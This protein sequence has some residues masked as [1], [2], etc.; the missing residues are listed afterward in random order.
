VT[1][2]DLDRGWTPD[3]LAT[4][5]GHRT[6]ESQALVLRAVAARLRDSAACP[7]DPASVL[8]DLGAAVRSIA[9]AARTA[10]AQLAPERLADPDT[11]DEVQ[12]WLNYLWAG[13][14]GLRRA[15]KWR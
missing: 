4:L 10:I 12:T 2:P 7:E 15:S 13:V 6:P 5:L 14:E 3:D 1:K 11:R 9:A 8:E